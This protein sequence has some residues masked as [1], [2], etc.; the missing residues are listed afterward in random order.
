MAI[1]I[2]TPDYNGPP[3]SAAAAARIE[4]N[5]QLCAEIDELVKTEPFPDNFLE[6]VEGRAWEPIWT[7]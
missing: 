5:R 2:E 3:V 4:A 1:I 7:T 6:L